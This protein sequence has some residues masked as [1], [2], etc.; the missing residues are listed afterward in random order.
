MLVVVECTTFEC[1]PSHKLLKTKLKV[2]LLSACTGIFTFMP[3]I[4]CSPSLNPLK[5]KASAKMDGA[6]K[7]GV[8]ASIEYA[9]QIRLVRQKCLTNP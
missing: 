9:L 4:E 5:Y 3:Y 8:I 7:Q 2:I 1:S 6:L